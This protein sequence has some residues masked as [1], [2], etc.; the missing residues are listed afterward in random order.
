MGRN[1]HMISLKPLTFIGHGF[2]S[3]I[4]NSGDRQKKRKLPEAHTYWN[5]TIVSQSRNRIT[6]KQLEILDLAWT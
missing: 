1:L 6:N 2:K 5:N 4:D 3:E